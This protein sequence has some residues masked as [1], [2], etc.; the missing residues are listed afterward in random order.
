M[1]TIE[2][3]LNIFWVNQTELAATP[4]YQLHFVRYSGFQSG[5]QPSKLIVG[6][7][8]LESYLTELGFTPQNARQ[9]IAQAH[10]N[11]SVSI[12]NVMLPEQYLAPYLAPSA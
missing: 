3:S 12:P 9:W 4:K 1:N 10:E 2:G 5:A 11:R 8:G 7:D 6:A